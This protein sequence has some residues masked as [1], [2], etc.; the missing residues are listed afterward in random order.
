MIDRISPE[1][2]RMLQEALN[3]MQSV[4]PDEKIDDSSFKD[5]LSDML[6]EVDEAQ[7]VADKSIEGLVTGET[8]S[9]QDVVM[10]MEE[11]DVAFQLMKEIRDK[12]INAYKEVMSMQS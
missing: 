4:S 12:L 6:N 2:T 9:I 3:N 8:K 7:K 1:A 11:A 10:K 5:M